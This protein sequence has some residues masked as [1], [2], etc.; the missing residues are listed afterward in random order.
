VL[1]S[2]GPYRSRLQGK[3][4]QGETERSSRHRH[5]RQCC[6]HYRSYGRKSLSSPWNPSSPG[7]CDD[8]DEEVKEVRLNAAALKDPDTMH[9]PISF[10]DYSSLDSSGL[11]DSGSSHC[12]ADPVF[13]SSN[14][15]PSYD[16]PPVTL[17]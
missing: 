6:S 9:T 10:P 14:N 3:F 11:V 2:I 13:I 4:Q 15:L 8:S 7:D 16:I 17:R 1:W 5:S 12:F